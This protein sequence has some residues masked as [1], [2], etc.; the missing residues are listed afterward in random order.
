LSVFLINSAPNKFINYSRIFAAM[1]EL[2]LKYA[3][4][5][6]VKYKGKANFGAIIGKVLAEDPSLKKK[7]KEI[8][9]EIKKIV[10][11]VNSMDKQEQ[12]NQLGKHLQQL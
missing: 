6:A 7:A 3:L 1:K 8:G 12:K 2:I 4:Q 10:K 9:M 11:Q 5:N